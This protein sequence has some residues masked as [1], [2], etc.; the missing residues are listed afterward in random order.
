MEVVAATLAIACLGRAS[1]FTQSDGK[2]DLM[3]SR[4]ELPL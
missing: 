1:I 4:N 3:Q 2:D